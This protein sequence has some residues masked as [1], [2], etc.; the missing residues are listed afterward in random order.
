MFLNK[1]NSPIKPPKRLFRVIIKRLKIEKN[2]KLFKEKFS[3]FS[4]LLAISIIL[5]AAAILLFNY[6]LKDSES[7]SLISLLFLNTRI[8]IAHFQ[9]FAMAVLESMPIMSIIIFI[10]S[11]TLVMIFLRFLVQYYDRIL[12]LHKLIKNK[13]Y[14]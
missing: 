14:G 6:D 4:A 13:K 3:V 2:L 1:H 7:V 10:V 12:T 5:V 11:I 8:I 9:Y